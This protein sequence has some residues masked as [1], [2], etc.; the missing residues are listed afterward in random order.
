[1]SRWGVVWKLGAAAFAVTTGL[2]WW[3]LRVRDAGLHDL[4]FQ[5]ASH[6]DSLGAHVRAIQAALRQQTWRPIGYGPIDEGMMLTLYGET[7]FCESIHAANDVT[8][9]QWEGPVPG[10][11]DD[12]VQ[13]VLIHMS[14][15]GTDDPAG[16]KN[17]ADALEPWIVVLDQIQASPLRY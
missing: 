10:V 14:V 16:R 2:L 6:C 1:M 15:S 7:L 9:A 4:R 17:A 8:R 12:K 13:S 5:C 11:A 3:S